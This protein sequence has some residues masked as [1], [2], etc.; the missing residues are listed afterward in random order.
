MLRKSYVC[1]GF[2]KWP[3]IRSFEMPTIHCSYRSLIC[4]CVCAT[5]I[6]RVCHLLNGLC[7]LDCTSQVSHTSTQCSTF[8]AMAVSLRL[9][10]VFNLKYVEAICFLISKSTFN[11]KENSSRE[12]VM[13][14]SA[15]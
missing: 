8:F 1:Q 10:V 5:G 13:V 14:N 9:V 12:N 7:A 15:C 2:I 4:V 11:L 6:L 3:E